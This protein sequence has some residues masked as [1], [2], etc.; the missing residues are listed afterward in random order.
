MKEHDI[1]GFNP[2]KLENFKEDNHNLEEENYDDWLENEYQ[3]AYNDLQE[4]HIK[5]CLHREER[6]IR[7]FILSLL[8]YLYENKNYFKNTKSNETLLKS[9]TIHKID[10]YFTKFIR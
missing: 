9:R 4:D 6:I 3:K 10:K 8:N 7:K 2:S 5:N 1:L